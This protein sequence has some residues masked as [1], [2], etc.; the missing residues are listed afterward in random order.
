MSLEL[1]R[2]EWLEADGHGG[3]AMGTADG[4][5]TR[6]Y[7]ALLL[8]ATR[9]PE[10][11]V[12]LVADVEVWLETPGGRFALSSHRYGGGGVV[13]PDGASRIVRF[14][15]EPWPTW[16][17]SLPDGTRVRGE[18][19]VAP[20]TARV[21]MRWTRVAGMGAAWLSVQPL[22]AGR[23]YHST[24]HEN[25][26]FGFDAHGDGDRVTWH[27]YPGIPAI[28]AASNGSYQ[29]APEWFRASHLAIEQ[30]RGLDCVEDLASPGAFKFDLASEPAALAFATGEAVAGGAL[31][32]A[33][34]ALVQRVYVAEATRR[35]GYSSTLARAAD[36]YI[37]ARGDGKTVIAGYPWFADWGRDTFISLRG[38]CLATG[39]RDV[40]RGILLE[41]CRVVSEGMLP[42]RF[43]ETSSTPEFNSVD[44]ALW[45][46]IAADAYLQG[47]TEAADREVLFKAID[48]IVAGYAAGTRHRIKADVDGL[49]AAGEPGVQLTWMDAKCGDHVITPRIGKPVEINALWINALAIAGRR[50]PKW[51]ALAERARTSFASRFWDEERQ[52]LFDVID[53]DHVPGTVDAT[54][55][56]NQIF[57]VG[58]LPLAVIEGDR[59]RAVVDT[60]ERLLWTEAGPRTIAEADARF[61]P[62]YGGGP[63]ERDSGYHNGPVWPWLAGGFVEAWVRTR[64]DT[65]SVRLEARRRFLDPLLGRTELF[66]LGHLSEI[67]DGAAPHRPTGC[68]FQAWS[69][70]EALRLDLVVLK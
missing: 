70:A 56:P 32:G 17:W 69:V 54:V 51:R 39:R 4:I 34:L 52:Q 48:A 45:F 24:H 5:R 63:L 16:E 30:E 11:R 59:A 27:P 43:D 64:G 1:G 66:G 46:V 28:V 25:G 31:D 22:L 68:P 50:T 53:C 40:A 7:H 20:G 37:V 60:V 44:A 67:C 14:Q 65:A 23:D 35:A 12:V 18:L 21:A 36:A 47:A 33:A 29:H 2:A 8:A 9:P 26:A 6:R 10:G 58:G 13:H 41:W 49:V 15:H 57:A 62:T 3:F 55:R 38:L 42:N 61:H 19:V